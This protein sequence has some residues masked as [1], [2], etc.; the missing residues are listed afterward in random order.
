[1][2]SS[3]DEENEEQIEEEEEVNDWD[4]FVQIKE[5]GQEEDDIEEEL[6]RS[7]VNNLFNKV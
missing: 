4:Q 5:E 3:C 2:G 1:M 6:S 7:Y